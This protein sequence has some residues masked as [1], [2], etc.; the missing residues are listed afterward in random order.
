MKG[1]SKA[2][3]TVDSY[4]WPGQ[5]CMANTLGIHNEIEL[6]EAVNKYAATRMPDLMA[7][8]IPERFDADYLRHIHKTLFQDCYDWAGEYRQCPMGR[9]MDYA[10]PESIPRRVSEFCESFRRDVLVPVL[11]ERELADT[12]ALKW[13]ALNAIHPF[14]DGNGRSQT[15]FFTA[16]CRSIGYDLSFSLQDRKNLRAAR[17]SASEGRAGLL[18]G[19]IARSLQPIEGFERKP[20]EPEVKARPSALSRLM[21]AL[22]RGGRDDSLDGPGGPE[23]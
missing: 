18:A 9:N 11:P 6:D 22:R 21:G 20:P 2:Y 1:Q 13:A 12:L 10:D 23:L 8:A 5:R 4:L 16:A 14:R 15:M 7:E 3:P 19:M 17:D